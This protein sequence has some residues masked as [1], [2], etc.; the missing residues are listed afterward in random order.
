MR[1]ERKDKFGSP[2]WDIKLCLSPFKGSKC[3]LVS[4]VRLK[5]NIWCIVRC[6]LL[7]LSVGD[8]LLLS[9]GEDNC[10]RK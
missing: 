1:K 4:I 7:L 3:D 2:N 6:A 10:H 5:G 9:D 8:G